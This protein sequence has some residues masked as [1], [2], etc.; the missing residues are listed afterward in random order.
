VLRPRVIPTLLLKGD[1]LVKGIRFKQHRYIGD[2]MNAVRIFNEKNVDELVFLDIAATEEQRKPRLEFIEKVAEESFMPFAVGGGLRTIEDIRQTLSCG[3]EKVVLNTAAVETPYLISQVAERF[4]S[5]SVVVSIDYRRNWFGQHQVVIQSGSKTTRLP[6]VE[7]AVEAVALGAGEILLTS[8][9][10]DGMMQG[11]DLEILAQVT[12]AVNVP[13]IVSGGAGAADH[14]R[15]A[16]RIG[17]ASAVAA[18]SL[19]V[20]HGPRRA[21]L[22]NYLSAVE[23]D[24]LWRCNQ[25]EDNR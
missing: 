1:G 4:G 25:V 5:Q 23:L 20:F 6:P 17:R 21:V 11:Y 16:I 3:A 12:N 14:M 8:I 22:I 7:W 24:M 2:P 15:E 9:E 19:F 18:G 13:V 10:R